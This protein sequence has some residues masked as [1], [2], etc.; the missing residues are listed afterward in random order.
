M[1]QIA[2]GPVGRSV[3]PARAH[4]WGWSPTTCGLGNAGH[5]TPNFGTYL[6]IWTKFG[7][8]P[9]WGP[10]RPFRAKKLQHPRRPCLKTAICRR[11]FR[12]DPTGRFR[13]ALIASGPIIKSVGDGHSYR[14]SWSKQPSGYATFESRPS[15]LL[16]AGRSG[17]NFGFASYNPT[18]QQSRR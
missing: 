7:W 3:P 18:A 2:S 9:P 12:L 11:T 14:G 8:Q 10:T 4:L 6:P 13:G 1:A 15:T 17:P 5:P 16:F